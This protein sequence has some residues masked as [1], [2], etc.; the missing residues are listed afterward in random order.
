MAGEGAASIGGALWPRRY[1]RARQ[2]RPGH[3]VASETGAVA[4][5]RRPRLQAAG[6]R[7]P[8]APSVEFFS[9]SERMR[10][11]VTAKIALATAGAIGGVPGSPMPPHLAPPDSAKCVSMTGESAIRAIS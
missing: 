4:D 7:C 1:S 10:L 8:Y 2:A 9:G 5:S 6:F 3:D 11:P